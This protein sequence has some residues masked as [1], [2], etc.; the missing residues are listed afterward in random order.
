MIKNQE[1]KRHEA[2]ITISKNATYHITFQA[3]NHL[4]IMIVMIV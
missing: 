2:I 4:N 1:K 3:A